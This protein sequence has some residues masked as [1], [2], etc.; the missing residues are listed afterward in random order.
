MFAELHIERGRIRAVLP[1]AT[2]TIIRTE[3]DTYEYPGCHVLPGFVDS[4]AHVVGYGERLALLSLYDASSLQDCVAR[5]A[6]RVRMDDS[7]VRAMGWNH[8]NWDVPNLPT[9][10]ALDVCSPAVPVVAMRV[11]GHAMWVNT[12][13]LN[14]AGIDP[15]NHPGVLIDDAMQPVWDAMPA[16]SIAEVRQQVLAATAEWVRHG[17]T[18]IHDMD[19][20]PVWLEVFRELAESGQLPVRIQSFVRGQH[21]EWIREGLLPAGG[22]LHRIAGVKLFADGALGS[23]GALLRSP[24]TDDASTHGIELL[25][26]PELTER[27]IEIVEAGWPCIA[28]H[29]IGDA[30]VRNV[31]DAYRVVRDHP[32]GS[33]MILRIEHAQHVAPEDVVRMAEMNI[34]ACVQSSHCLSDASMAEKRL[35]SDRLSWS[36]RW[37]SLLSTGVTITGGSD[38]PIESPSVL[39]GLHAFVH[40][41]PRGHDASWCS[42]ER[43]SC[44]E[45]VDAYTSVAHCASGMEYRRGRVEVGYDADLVIVSHDL[46]AD[47]DG[48]PDG[49]VV[50]A[51]LTAG[52]LRYAG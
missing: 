27:M 46:C 8:E 31:L 4:H 2:G 21:R 25:S 9:R 14:A 51:T 19:V 37:R 10:E 43:I 52:R 49:V 1:C 15:T 6:D 7:W 34:I 30:A 3:T 33:D 5:I 36:Y 11:D 28:V 42:A 41:I 50:R 38:A 16:S 48:V 45:A 23:R 22:E 29:A 44:S 12:A 35:G 24:Y 13:A 17:V 39:E 18:E 40:R 26:V 32:S 20:A 47:E